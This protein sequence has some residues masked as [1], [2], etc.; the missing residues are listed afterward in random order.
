MTSMVSLIMSFKMTGVNTGTS[1]LLY[2]RLLSSISLMT[3]FMV[4]AECQINFESLILCLVSS[5]LINF[6][7]S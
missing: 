4:E 1:I 3:N 5:V 2:S 7:D 6:W